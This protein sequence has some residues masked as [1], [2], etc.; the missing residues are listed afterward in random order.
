[1][2]LVLCKLSLTVVM[3]HDGST[4]GSMSE[5]AKWFAMEEIRN[6][7]ECESVA[8][9]HSLDDLPADWHDSLPY[10]TTDEPMPDMTCRQILQ[11]EDEASR[12]TG[13]RR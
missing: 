10:R 1:M 9:V 12:K 2:K 4:V 3:E 8:A 11:A 6:G 5:K 13:G 7:L